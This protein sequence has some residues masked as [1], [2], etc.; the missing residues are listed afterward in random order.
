METAVT[1]VLFPW[2]ALEFVRL[3]EVNNFAQF[4]KHLCRISADKPPR[5]VLSCNV[6][7]AAFPNPWCIFTVQVFFL[8]FAASR[9][10]ERR[11]LCLSSSAEALVSRQPVCSNIWH[12]GGQTW[13][14][15]R[16]PEATTTTRIPTLTCESDGGMRR[17]RFVLNHGFS[18]NSRILSPFSSRQ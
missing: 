10:E 15:Q 12:H 6:R 4:H 2:F 5:N 8:A 13:S 17:K 9:A 11:L 3:F 1:R 7:T 18:V 16:R 14:G